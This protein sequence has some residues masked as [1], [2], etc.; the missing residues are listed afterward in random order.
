MDFGF[1]FSF[2]DSRFYDLD[3]R[4]VKIVVGYCPW[5]VSVD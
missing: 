5:I 2:L 4:F 1:E 3:L